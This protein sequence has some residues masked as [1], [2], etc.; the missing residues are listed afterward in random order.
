MLPRTLIQHAG[1]QQQDVEYHEINEAFA[2]VALV[3]MKVRFLSV[4]TQNAVIQTE[5]DNE[6]ELN[7]LFSAA[8]CRANTLPIRP[9]LNCLVCVTTILPRI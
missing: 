6:P 9:Q 2:V 1:L 8:F 4:Q 3:N 7:M 5:L